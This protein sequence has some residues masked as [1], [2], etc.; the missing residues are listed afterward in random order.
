MG[1]DVKA[2]NKK[3]YDTFSITMELEKPLLYDLEDDKNNKSNK[4]NNN[5]KNDGDN[6]IKPSIMK[7][8]MIG[9]S[10]I[11]IM[12]IIVFVIWANIT[13]KP[14]MLAEEALVSD[15]NV[16]VSVNKFISF[17]PIGKTP[18]KGFIFYPGAK[19][20]P[21]AYAP[22]CKAIAEKGYQVVIVPMPLNLAT[23]SIN[24]GEKV[25]DKYQSIDTWIVGGH[26]LGGT[27][28]AKFARN[29]NNVDGVVL[30][31]SYP[32]GDELKD[33]GK[34]VLSIWGSKDGV[35]NFENLINAKANL[36]DDTTYVEIEGANHSQFADYG[37][38]KGD[39]EAIVSQEK[40]LDITTSSILKFLKNI[41]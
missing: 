38:Q 6:G 28:A 29:N 24:K 10:A 1:K 5:N 16:E 32:M 2:K 11:L 8:V 31:A 22:L 12:A 19:I 26:S 40:Q 30:L 17:S 27:M 25:I 13:Y 14:Q 37:D 15:K 3:K 33:L 34:D 20:D 35:L 18:T 23:L 21:E 39:N 41:K 4:T 9:I 7:K 36:P